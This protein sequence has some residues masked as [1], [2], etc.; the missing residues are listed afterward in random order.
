MLNHLSRPTQIY[1]VGFFAF[2]IVVSIVFFLLSPSGRG[3][4]SQYT[5]TMYYSGLVLGI[6]GLIL[7]AE[8]ALLQETSSTIQLYNREKESALTMVNEKFL[9]YF[10]DSQRLYFQMNA[11]K[12]MFSQDAPSSLNSTSARQI[13][14]ENVL[15]NIVFRRIE[16][17]VLTNASFQNFASVQQTLRGDSTEDVFLTPSLVRTWKSWFQ[18]A[19]LRDLWQQNKTEY[20]SQTREFIDSTLLPAAV[21]S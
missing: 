11:T 6:M 4:L 20:T 12:P 21:S 16:E 1:L 8:A 2:L 3:T 13:M 5:R 19:L 10:P 15:A 7:S 9:Q 18:S 14:V 17:I